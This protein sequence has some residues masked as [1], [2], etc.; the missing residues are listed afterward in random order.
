MRLRLYHHSDGAR[1]AYREQGTGPPLILWHSELLSWKEFEPLVEELEHRYRV[2]L[3]DL[4]LHGDSEDRPHHPYS[5]DWL[6]EV[7][8]GFCNDVGG[9]RPMVGGHGLGVELVLRA[10]AQGKLTPSKLVVM[11]NRLH[12]G[13][14]GDREWAAWLA[15]ARL[16]AVPGIDRVL[17]RGAPYAL[18]P[19]RGRGLS[20]RSNP[21]ATE[22][23]RQS[24]ANAGGNSNL[25]RSWG[26]FARTRP[27]CVQRELIE[28][29]SRIDIPVL[30]LWPEEDPRCPPAAAEEALD[31]LPD[32]QLRLLAQTGHLAAY[33]DPV[34]VAR[35]ISAF[36]G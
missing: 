26:A 34:A 33:D 17:M 21:Q 18:R 15:L 35:E 12:R 27:N 30:L 25:A 13:G 23:A 19:G 2:V 28:A 8:A 6:A 29:Y 7:V 9:S 22:L 4:P 16:G 20:A 24:F 14:A 1:V 31:L 10:V 36:C 3:P 11:A 32:A 5:L